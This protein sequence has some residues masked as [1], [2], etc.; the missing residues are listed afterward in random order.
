MAEQVYELNGE[1]FSTVGEYLDAAAHEYKHGDKDL[2]ITSLE[3]YG[4]SM[5]DLNIGGHQPHP[6]DVTN[7]AHATQPEPTQLNETSED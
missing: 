6:T 7:D 1:L 3:N 2:A 5:S 4:F